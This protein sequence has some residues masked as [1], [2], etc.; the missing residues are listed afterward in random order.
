MKITLLYFSMLFC[1]LQVQFS[2][3]RFLT[4]SAFLVSNDIYH[5][6]NHCNGFNFNF[7]ILEMKHEKTLQDMDTP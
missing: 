5:F 6:S 4:A 1:K 3:K 7:C 2:D